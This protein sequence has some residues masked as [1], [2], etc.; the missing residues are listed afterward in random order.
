MT[1][2]DVT[3]PM[4]TW[5]QDSF[6]P[7]DYVKSKGERRA[8]LLSLTLFGITML[9]VV[10][11]FFATNRRWMSVRDQQRSINAMYVREA[12]KIE[13]LKELEKQRAEMVTKAEVTAA[14]VERVPRSVLFAELVTRMPAD[15]TLTEFELTSEEVKKT[16]GSKRSSGVRTLTGS[17]NAS[18]NNKKNEEEEES[19][20]Y[21]PEF[22][23]KLRIVGVGLSNDDIA[24]YIENL[25]QCEL[26]DSVELKFI[27]ESKID[28]VLLRSFE[29]GAAI[30]K[31]ADA[32]GLIEET[33]PI[34]MPDI[35]TPDRLVP[36]MPLLLPPSV[37]GEEGEG[38]GAEGEAGQMEI[39]IEEAGE[40]EGAEDA[41]TFEM[42]SVS[43]TPS[44]PFA[45]SESKWASPGGWFDLMGAAARTAER[46]RSEKA[47]EAIRLQNETDVQAPTTDETPEPE[48]EAEAETEEAQAP[49]EGQSPAAEVKEAAPSKFWFRDPKPAEPE[50]EAEVAPEEEPEAESTEEDE[51]ETESA[52]G[53]G[54]VD[55][56]AEEDEP[57]V[58][59]DEGDKKENG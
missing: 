9:A 23:Q 31:G 33:K 49:V 56:D 26:L 28:G 54:P 4:D 12:E 6:L 58:E 45:E 22:H 42:P 48:G 38:A 44:L 30:R 14:L 3:K 19:S 10:G 16:R 24:D 59:S 52:E 8:N 50:A 36:Q 34:E 47:A 27:K 17:G 32:R 21:I 51:P 37:E 7:E 35:R 46:T 18:K 5:E 43:F 1:E 25:R 41:V 13:E 2:S 57:E 53:A 15:L 39:T 40:F 20:V 29:L 11:A 55:G